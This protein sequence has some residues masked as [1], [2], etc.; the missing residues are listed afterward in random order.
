MSTPNT[1]EELTS[2]WQHYVEVWQASGMTQAEF[3]KQHDLLYHRFIYWKQKFSGN[4]ARQ[5]PEISTG[6]FVKVVPADSDSGLSL[7]LPTGLVI[8]GL[9][10]SNLRLVCRLAEQ[11]S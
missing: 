6:G 5:R 2:Y 11:L 10:E 1:P 9:K 3:C 4:Q 8:R 7:T